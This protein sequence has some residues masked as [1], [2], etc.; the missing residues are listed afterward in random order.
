MAG[1]KH[2]FPRGRILN[3]FRH[4]SSKV[5]VCLQT[6]ALERKVEQCGLK[7]LP[8]FVLRAG[9]YLSLQGPPIEKHCLAARNVAL[10]LWAQAIGLWDLPSKPSVS[11]FHTCSKPSV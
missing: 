8:L 1:I 5:Y 9:K 11:L 7:V 10:M 4:R 3:I 6:E 2:G